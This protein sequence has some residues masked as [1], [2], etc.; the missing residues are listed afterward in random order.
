M[1]LSYLQLK[2]H[3]N[4]MKKNHR[5]LVPAAL[6]ILFQMLLVWNG[7]KHEPILPEDPLPPDT[8]ECDTLNVTFNG[9]V[10]PILQANCLGC[11]SG[12]QPSYGLDLTNFDHLAA[13]VNDG[14]LVGAINHAQGFYPMPKDGTMLSACD[15]LII[16]IW[17]NDTVFGD[18]P[19]DTTNI[20]YP[21]TI[22]PLLQD[23]CLSCH[24]GEQPSGNLDFTNY[25]HVAIVAQNG[26]LL[27][28]LKHQAGYSPMPKDGSQLDD[29][30]I[31]KIEK[32][33]ND[34]TFSD[35][36]GGVDQP[37]DPDT[38]YFQNEIFPLIN[39]TCATIGCHNQLGEEQDVLLV[40]YSSIMSYGEIVPGNPD[41]SKLFEK[42]TDDDPDDRMPPPPN[43]PLTADQINLI[44]TW[45]EQGAQNNYCDEDC[46]TTNVTFSGTIWPMIELNCIGC[47]SGPQPSGNIS[48][49]NYASI[50]VQAES[51][52]L[53]GA[54]SHSAGFSPMPKNAPKLSDC[55]IEQVK[56]WIEDGTPN[57]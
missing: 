27:G 5:Y 55:K 22:Y 39:S 2:S 40:D 50:V 56:I 54:I 42:I 34:T 20:T 24:S 28:A 21:G 49:E 47:H 15:I 9:S 26:A 13:I 29:C 14:S 25:D 16:E 8:S 37:C 32:W 45:I 35:P 6:L 3:M 51:G 10:L 44:R 18:I 53:F 52:R 57:N 43:D 7:C 17:A 30:T 11:H 36:G 19:C 38:V 4:T 41:E 48:L 12:S 23:K 46:D 1:P 33:I 31:L